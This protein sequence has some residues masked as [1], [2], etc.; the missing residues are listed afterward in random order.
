MKKYFAATLLFFVI[1]LI[2]F[3][4]LPQKMTEEK[5]QGPAPLQETAKKGTPE[6]HTNRVKPLTI[7]VK[8]KKKV[9]FTGIVDHVN[10]E[11]KTISLRYKGKVL[12]FDMN[13]PMLFGYNSVGDIKKGDTLS[14]GY[15]HG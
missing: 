5:E 14:V 15:V 4:C 9:D 11:T 7:R 8:T 3:N 6:S 10:V 12:S 2:S 1:T 13:N